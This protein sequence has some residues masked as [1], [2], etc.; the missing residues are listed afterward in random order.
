MKRLLVLGGSD[1]QVSLIKQAKSLGHYII[2]CDYLPDNPGHKFAD[3]YFDVSTTDKEGVYNLAKTL[4]LD[5]ISAY[6]S[7]PAAETAAWV[8]EKLNLPTNPYSAVKILS[9]KDLF[10]QHMVKHNFLVPKSKSFSNYSE[11]LVYSKTLNE[12]CIIKPV[13]SSGSK[14][15]FVLDNGLSFEK[16]FKKAMSFSRVKRVIIEQFIIKKGYQ[17]GGD[18][19]LVNGKLVFRCFGDIHFSKTNPLLPCAVS[20]PTLHNE[21][22]KKK[23][24]NTIQNLMNSLDMKFGALNFDVLIDENDNVHIIEIGPRNGGNLLPELIEL[25]TGVDLKLY[26]IKSA[27]GEDCS[28]L[29]MKHEKSFFSHYVVHSQKNGTFVGISKSKEIDKKIL[30]ENIRVSK[31]DKVG[32]FENSSNR[33]GMLLLKYD[34]KS[35]MQDIIND[36]ENHFKILIK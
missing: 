24:H 10:R 13:D 21:E 17:I 29:K 9:Q 3:E 11:A 1:L 18:G 12:K 5:G 20:V 27:L 16:E 31:Y 7:D 15:V 25:C 30:F 28:T 4:E 36:M 23:V 6:A 26:T 19:F 22:I 8:C 2:T 32:K 35:Q 14:G 33:L 34:N